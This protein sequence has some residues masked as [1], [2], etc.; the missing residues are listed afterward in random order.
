MAV[1][2]RDRQPVGHTALT[3]TPAC[4]V[5]HTVL[6]QR[7]GGVR[8]P[9]ADV[10][11]EIATSGAATARA[12]WGAIVG[13]SCVA[14]RGYGDIVCEGCWA[15][16]SPWNPQANVPGSAVPADGIIRLYRYDGVVRDV[17]MAI[18]RRSHSAAGARFS[19]A[20][21]AA[22]RHYRPDY[23]VAVPDSIA[24]WR[25][26][27]FGVVRSVLVG[28]GVLLTSV[29]SLRDS[30]TQEGRGRTQRHRARAD[31]LWVRDARRVRGARVVIVD[32]VVT[33]GA[34]MTAARRALEAAGA[35]VVACIAIAGVRR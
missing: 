8:T 26:R 21:A 28:T 12:A 25:R 11:T 31:A 2:G 34:T 1:D 20:L 19:V 33:T 4:A 27:G 14:C 13:I 17:I 23:V 15:R 29:L 6:G 9:H 32:D 18:K 16:A 24:G 5:V 10:M 7:H 35:T 30:G 22:I 3:A